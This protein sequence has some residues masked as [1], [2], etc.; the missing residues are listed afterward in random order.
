ML[1]QHRIDKETLNLPKYSRKGWI[2]VDLD[3]T[4]AHAD[5]T[6][7]PLYI[8]P[9]VPQMLKRVRYWIKTGRT[10]KI[11][12]SRAG[13]PLNERLIHQWCLQHGLP[14]LEI[15]NRKDHRMLALWDDRAVGVVKNAGVPLLPISMGFWQLVRLRLRLLLGGKILMQHESRHLESPHFSAVPMTGELT[16]ETAFHT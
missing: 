16:H 13:D 8:G 11:F 15:T 12:T 5:P 14:K 3:G 9:A 6:M 10:V 2:G 7:H 4:L 1:E